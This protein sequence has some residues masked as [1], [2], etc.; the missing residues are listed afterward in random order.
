VRA[1]SDSAAGDGGS[2]L[3]LARPGPSREGAPAEYT[4]YLNRFRQR[5]QETMA[6]PSSARRRGISGT[7]QLDV[8]ID[9][10]GRVRDVEV[11]ASSAHAVL[12]EAAVDAVRRMPPL[13]FPAHVVPRA[14]RVRLPLVFD[15]R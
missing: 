6:Y 15:L 2:R 9:A 11:S 7:V 12:D 3:A 1:G 10:T 5:V 14:L 4:A 8:S 13:P